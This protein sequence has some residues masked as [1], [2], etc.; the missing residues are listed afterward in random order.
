MGIR[1]KRH[2]HLTCRRAIEAYAARTALALDDVSLNALAVVDVHHLNLL[3]WNDV[4]GIHQRLVNGDR[5]DVVEVGLRY[6]YTVDF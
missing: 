2:G 6:R 4:G 3:V 5:T 1:I